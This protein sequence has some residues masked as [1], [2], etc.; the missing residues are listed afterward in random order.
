MLGCFRYVF[1]VQI[2]PH[3]VFGSLG[4]GMKFN[5]PFVEVPSFFMLR[6]RTPLLRFLVR[7]FPK[8]CS[9]PLLVWSEVLSTPPESS[10]NYHGTQNWRFGWKTGGLVGKLEVWLQN[11]RFGCKTGG[12]VGKLEVWLENDF[13]FEVCVIFRTLA[14]RFRWFLMEGE[15]L[16]A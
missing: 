1:G 4:L 9:K 13:P 7:C 8:W 11:W 14:V 12:L 15:C 6:F 10:K 3:K 5:N 16:P 2:P